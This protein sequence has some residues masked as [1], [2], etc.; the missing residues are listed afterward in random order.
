MLTIQPRFTN[1]SSYNTSFKG[2]NDFI[3]EDKYN[4][5]KNYYGNQKLE[6]DKII[7][8]E[9][10]PEGMKKGA[11]AFKV[12]SEGV[13]EGWAV[14]WGATTGGKFLKTGLLKAYNSKFAKWASK[15]LSPISQGIKK[16]SKNFKTSFSKGIENIKTS[17]FVKNIS[18]KLT[19]AEESL[20]KTTLGKAL[21]TGIKY[22]GKAFKA[23]GKVISM[24]GSK[25]KAFTKNMTYE[26]ASKAT[27]S[28]LG[29]GSGVAGA[30]SAAREEIKKDKSEKDIRSNNDYT[31]E[32]ENFNEN[33]AKESI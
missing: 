13:L 2:D 4:E 29:V 14:A 11:K 10:V 21:V 19:K 3:T 8:D 20:N 33:L 23:V 22:I 17:K 28:T 25:I 1:Q 5:K 15:M 9:Y 12:I 31:D 26:K 24:I 32:V 18:A 27:A 30:Y 16:S 6:F 7:N